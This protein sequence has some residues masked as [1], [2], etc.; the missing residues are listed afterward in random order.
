MNTFLDLLIVVVMAIVAVGIVAA[1][2][3][4]LVKNE[5][6]RKISFWVIALLGIYIGYV[7]VRIMRLGFP[8]Q[9]LVAVVM[10]LV[11]VG[12]IVLNLIGKNDEKKLL[13]AR[14]MA[15]VAL[16]VGTVNAFS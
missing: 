12:A 5:K 14:I 7:G 10:A 4:F 13:A 9:T 8:L 16:A 3:M 11:S 1:G 6:V 15:T 2:L